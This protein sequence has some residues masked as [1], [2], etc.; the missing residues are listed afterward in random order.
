MQVLQ[1]GEVHLET[2]TSQER[3][4]DTRNPLFEEER[5]TRLKY[6]RFKGDGN[7]DADE[8]LSEFEST[9]LANQ[10]GEAA[11]RRIIQGLLKGE[12]LK[13]YQDIPDRIRNDWDQLKT[14]FLQ[15]FREVGGESRSLGKLSTMTMKS[16]E[17]VRKYGQRV[18]ALIQKV[19]TEIAPRLQVEWY[20]AGLPESMGF[21]IRQTRPA[22]LRDAMDA[23]ANYENSAKSLRNSSRKS[24]KEKGKSKKKDRK[25]RHRKRASESESSSES[26]N[27]EDSDL[28]PQARK[29]IEVSHH[30]GD[31]RD[32]RAFEGKLFVK[33]KRR[34]RIPKR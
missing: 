25:S 11:Q 4:P 23:A 3:G 2:G 20:V 31:R 33:S 1:E 28:V 24:K 13:W 29:T 19:T 9:A 21:L 26:S 32:L 15:A 8:W 5:M 7:Q 18:K 34:T 14:D 16:S 6:K 30:Q 22:T 17:S 27:T 10:E 12:A